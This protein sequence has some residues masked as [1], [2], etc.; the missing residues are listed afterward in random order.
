MTFQ[1]KFL[2]FKKNYLKEI[3]KKCTPTQEKYL[4][5]QIFPD[6]IPDWDLESAIELIERTID[7]NE[8]KK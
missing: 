6:G 1:K 8:S 3:L 5:E 4:Y 2:E 7:K